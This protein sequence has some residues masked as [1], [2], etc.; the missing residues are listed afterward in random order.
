MQA[1]NG[2]AT[3]SNV[4]LSM[5]GTY[6]LTASVGNNNEVTATSQPFQVNAPPVIVSAG[7][8]S[9]FV[10]S[11]TPP[12]YTSGTPPYVNYTAASPVE[13]SGP[14]TA[15]DLNA[16]V[17]DDG[18]PNP[19]DTVTSTWS[20]TFTPNG[21]SSPTQTG[22]FG[23]QTQNTPANNGQLYFNTPATFAN[24]GVYDVTLTVSDGQLQTVEDFTIYVNTAPTIVSAGATSLA[25]TGG[26]P[27]YVNYTAA[28]PVEWTGP[29]TAVNLNAV[30]TD[31]GLPN[32]PDQVTL[33]WNYSYTAHGQSSPSAIGTFG[34][35]TSATPANDGQLYLNTSATFAPGPGLYDVTLT[36]SDGQLQTVDDFT[37][38]VNGPPVIVSAGATSPF[39]WSGTPPTY[40]SGTPPY[41]NYTAA[42]PVEWTGPATAVDLNAIVTDDGLPNPP[43]KVTST[44][45]Y[46]FTPNGQS[47]PTQTGT[48]GTQT[49]ATPANQSQ[50]SFNTPATFTAGSGIYDVTLTVSD[51]QL[52]TVDA[53]TIY[54]NA[55]PAIV[56]YGATGP[57]V[58]SGT[59]PTYTSGTPPYVSYTLASPLQWAGSTT[60]VDLNAIVTDDA[61]PN[62]PDQVTATWIYTYTPNG[63]TSPTQSGTFGNQ[64]QATPANYG[65]FYFNTPATFAAG[66]GVYDVILVVNDGQLQTVS[67]DFK[68]YVNS[69]VAITAP[70]TSS[71]NENCPLVF[72]SG[73]GNPISV[74]DPNAGSSVEQ[75]TLTETHGILTLAST[76]GLTFSAGSNKSSSMTVKGTLTN[77]NAALNGLTFTPTSGYFGGAALDAHLQGP[78]QQSDGNRIG[79]HQRGPPRQSADGDHR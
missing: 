5:P 8:T 57:V 35:Q 52:Q 16:I 43:D 72:C 7:E 60:A 36:V 56:S 21:Q 62:P 42:S 50:L 47:S 67:T 66:P 22:T 48:F 40:T 32:P 69:S 37:I 76:K 15:V 41:A 18:L 28:S 78:G 63:Q 3:F 55:P 10:W 44:W 79:L 75:L 2:V 54:V 38:Y 4:T 77:L 14:A 17:T 65:Q 26:T 6:T 64:T 11:G 70:P 30:V 27:T 25:V 53:F 68:I 13:W 20:Y 51:G 31:N 61:L 9:P 59:P 34:T 71:V 29:T 1:A 23:T 45:S 12:T 33:T 58:S 19:P 74:T 49:Q 39:V 24:P 73:N 46:T